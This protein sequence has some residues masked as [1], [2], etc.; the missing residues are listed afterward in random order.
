MIA[1]HRRRVFG[2]IRASL[3]DGL[4][5]HPDVGRVGHTHHA[6]MLAVT[7]AACR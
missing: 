2:E 1:A 4:Q 7:P 5:L 3:L 6:M